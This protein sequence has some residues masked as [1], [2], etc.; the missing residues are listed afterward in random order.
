[1]SKDNINPLSIIVVPLSIVALVSLAIP[2]V[3]IISLS[4]KAQSL[5]N[6]LKAVPDSGQAVSM[7]NGKQ[8]ISILAKGGYWPKT[9][10]A[11]AGVDTTLRINTQNTFDCSS[12]IN[13][14]TLG[15]RDALQ[16]SGVKEIAIAPQS[17]GSVINGTCSM[18]MYSFSIRFN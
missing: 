14:P 12:F 5:E 4:K 15:I 7:E 3:V 1:M 17:P 6:P 13:I 10:S 11:K 18:G 8:V 16:P 2:I 9:I